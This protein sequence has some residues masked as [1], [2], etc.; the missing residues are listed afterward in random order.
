M[1]GLGSLHGS[2]E[3]SLKGRPYLEASETRSPDVS[4]SETTCSDSAMDGPPLK[5]GRS[6][7]GPF[8]TA[9][10]GSQA[11][12]LATTGLLTNVHLAEALLHP[13]SFKG[14]R[15]ILS[16]YWISA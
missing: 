7:K 5:V 10:P 3:H 12:K 2:I 14:F 16:A 6:S 1:E 11:D 4:G 15:C 13:E 8:L 9:R